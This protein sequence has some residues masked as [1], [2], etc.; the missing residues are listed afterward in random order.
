MIH[1]TELYRL[2]KQMEGVVHGADALRDERTLAA[3]TNEAALR[4]IAGLLGCALKLVE[5]EPIPAAPAVALTSQASQSSVEIEG[6]AKGPPG[7][8]VKVYDAEPHKA[9]L[10]AAE[11]YD[12]T[13][14]K[15]AAQAQIQEGG[16]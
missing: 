15:Y 1:T 5:K 11:I 2:L 16:S 10:R 3:W 7:I 6:R 12:L 13:V 8:K 4:Q 9:M 14:A